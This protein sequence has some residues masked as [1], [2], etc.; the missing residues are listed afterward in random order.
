MYQIFERFDAL[1]YLTAGVELTL[2]LIYGDF[3]SKAI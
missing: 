2:F 3:A 1:Y